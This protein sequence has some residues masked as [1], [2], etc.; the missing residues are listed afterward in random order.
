MVEQKN[1]K[2]SDTIKKIKLKPFIFIADKL[3]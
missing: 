1:Q 3:K 2:I